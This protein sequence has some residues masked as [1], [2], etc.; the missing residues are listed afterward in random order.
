MAGLLLLG[1]CLCDRD[2]DVHGQ[3]PNAVLVVGCKV[4][5]KRDH[6]IDDDGWRHA[7]D[8]LRKVVGGLSPHHRGIV[9]YELAVVLSELLLRWRWGSCIR[10][11]VKTGRGDL[12]G[13]P[14]GLGKAQNKGDE[15]LLNLLL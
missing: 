14:V 6:L 10:G 11:A 5:E 12:R 8:E 9:M 15:V 1:H 13:E 2:Q 4:L 7:L 3:K